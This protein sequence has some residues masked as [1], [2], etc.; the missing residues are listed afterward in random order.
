MSTSHKR[1]ENKRDEFWIDDIGSLS[2]VC[3]DLFLQLFNREP[4]PE[5]KPSKSSNSKMERLV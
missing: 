1:N 5:T 2:L 4:I 3:D